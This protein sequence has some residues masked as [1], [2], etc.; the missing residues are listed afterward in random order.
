MNGKLRATLDVEKESTEQDV[1]ALAM[2]EVSVTKFVDG[3][4]VKKVV[5]VPGRILNIVATK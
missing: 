1:M 5:Y 4:T 3:L 2:K